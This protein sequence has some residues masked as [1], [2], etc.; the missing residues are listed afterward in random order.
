MPHLTWRTPASLLAVL[1]LAGC[2][3]ATRPSMSVPWIPGDG[4]PSGAFAEAVAILGVEADCRRGGERCPQAIAGAPGPLQPATREYALAEV[5]FRLARKGRSGADE[6]ALQCAAHAHRYLFAPMLE[7]RASAL[8]ATAQQALRLYNECAGLWLLPRVSG[9][10]SLRAL[11]PSWNVR[12][13]SDPRVLPVTALLRFAPEGSTRRPSVELHDGFAGPRIATALGEIP[14]AVE[15]TPAYARW[16]ATVPGS[17]AAVLD[18][19]SWYVDP[20]QPRVDLLQ[21]YG[22]QRVPVI[23]IDGLGSGP[24]TWLDLAND[25]LGDPRLGAR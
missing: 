10:D 24:N 15:F 5:W 23:L 11:D 17:T 6:A 9:L 14:L 8:E 13:A 1:C 20:V 18:L 21:P 16:A 3:G 2:A 7:G 4:P 25:L 12:Q 19:A 22:P